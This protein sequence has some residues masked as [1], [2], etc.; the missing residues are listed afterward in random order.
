MPLARRARR[1]VKDDAKTTRNLTH[2]PAAHDLTPVD[3]GIKWETAACKKSGA[4]ACEGGFVGGARRRR[5]FGRAV[6]CGRRIAETAAK[7]LLGQFARI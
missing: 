2:D 3:I 1:V 5:W 4:I 6:V 7:L